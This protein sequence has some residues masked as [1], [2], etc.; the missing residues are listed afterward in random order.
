MIILTS[1]QKVVQ[2]QFE[3]KRRQ[4]RSLSLVVFENPMYTNSFNVIEIQGGPGF[5]DQAIT[6]VLEPYRIRVL[7]NKLELENNYLVKSSL[8]PKY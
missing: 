2:K 8:E 5:T 4:S 3:A 6:C 7:N 1:P